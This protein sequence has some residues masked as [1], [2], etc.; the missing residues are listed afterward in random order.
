MYIALFIIC[1]STNE[2]TILINIYKIFRILHDG[3]KDGEANEQPETVSGK[4]S[5]FMATYCH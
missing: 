1:N 3:Q 5:D 4:E 2:G